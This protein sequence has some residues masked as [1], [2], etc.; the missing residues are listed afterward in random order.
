MKPS[1]VVKASSLLLITAV[2]A[3]SICQ[4]QF[5][6]YTGIG[7][8]YTPD[9]KMY[10]AVCLIILFALVPI[11]TEEES[12]YYYLS[13]G[14]GI[15]A[16]TIAVAVLGAPFYLDIIYLVVSNVTVVYVLALIYMSRV[17][18]IFVG[19]EDDDEDE[20]PSLFKRGWNNTTSYINVVILKRKQ[21]EKL[22]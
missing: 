14:I 3:I 9:G 11:V 22:K 6:E 18:G 1:I 13:T 15:S 2:S 5:M 4:I 19:H 21:N 16:F 8:Y 10:G 17:L 7:E 12:N 20:T